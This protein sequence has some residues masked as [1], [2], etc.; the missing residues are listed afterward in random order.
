[1]KK[2]QTLSHLFASY[3]GLL[4]LSVLIITFSAL[5]VPKYPADIINFDTN[6]TD[7][8]GNATD[9]TQINDDISF[10]NTLPD[11]DYRQSLFFRAKNIMV[12][13]YINGQLINDYGRIEMAQSFAYKAPGTYFIN[14]PLNPSYS[15]KTI[16]LRVV[17]PYKNDNS[18]NI[19][20]IYIGDTSVILK[21]EI[22]DKLFGFCLCA[23]IIVLG[24]V[25]LGISIPL[26]RYHKNS[27]NLIY[28]GTFA[29]V[30]GVWS[31]TETKLPQ[32]LFGHSTFWHIITGLSLLLTIPPLF[33][34]FK[35]KHEKTTMLPV[36]IV[37]ICTITMYMTSI[38][39][40]IFNAFDMHETISLAHISIICG[41]LFTLYYAGK[42]FIASKF[43][44]ASFWGLMIIAICAGTDIILYKFQITSDNST[45]VRIGIFGY[46]GFLGIEIIQDYIDTY[47]NYLKTEMI[48]K[49]AYFDILTDLYN[50]TSFNEDIR[51]F[52]EISSDEHN[53][54]IAIF[55][56]NNL[57][58]IND[59]FGHTSGDKAIVES[60]QYIKTLFSD[61]GKCY[62]IGGD[63]FVFISSD[64]NFT[65][66]KMKQI[67]DNLE[68]QLIHRNQKP[69]EKTPWALLIA[70]GY[71]EFNEDV[72]TMTDAFNT[73]DRMMYDNKK[74]LKEKYPEMNIRK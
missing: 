72:E 44:D 45:M 74:Q 37:N 58:Y 56:M 36:I 6:W 39:L 60:A 18:C 1:M 52:D 69:P 7:I 4:I 19:K 32:L 49:A 11:I 15:N 65:I 40:H 55:D 16:E 31:M 38:L 47:N 71:A 27:F 2:T 63:E 54:I 26:H 61:F 10:F 35:R 17:S 25:F 42:Y 41:V 57:K 28:L 67:S 73:A 64:K 33:L 14:I 43:K 8:N 12:S 51:A 70:I 34:F 22:A 68:Q 59:I 23:I 50:R 66:E 62:R 53:S 46:I 13:V 20:H 21:T 5:V 30:V 3:V 9:V 24:A 29:I 48:A